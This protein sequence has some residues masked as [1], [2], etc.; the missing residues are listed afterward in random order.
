MIPGI[1]LDHDLA[2]SPR[3]IQAI[4]LPDGK[5]GGPKEALKEFRILIVEDDYL[6]T[7]EMEAA[8]TQS[9]FEVA[10]IAMSADDALELAAA[11]HP[12]LVVMD[13]RLMGKRDGIDVALELFRKY[14]IRCIF[15]TA[16][17]TADARDRASPANP[18]AWLAKPYTMPSLVNTV[19]SAVRE[20]RG[21]QG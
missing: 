14:G 4:L 8:L 9:G 11:E 20:L 10:G 5:S 18:L 1:S 15:A 21:L 7:Q 3:S 2:M 17:Q 19:R 12:S 13:I 16:H 6:V